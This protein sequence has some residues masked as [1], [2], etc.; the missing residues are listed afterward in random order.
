MSPAFLLVVVGLLVGILLHGP[1]GVALIVIGA[2]LLIVPEL[3]R[4][5]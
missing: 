5:P 4:G 2:L 1:L 3:K